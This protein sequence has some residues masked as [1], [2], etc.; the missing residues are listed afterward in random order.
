MG[1][2]SGF[3]GLNLRVHSRQATDSKA[4][5]PLASRE[6]TLFHEVGWLTHL[7]S[8]WNVAGGGEGGGEGE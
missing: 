8:K 5:I 3:K 4:D 6:G 1:F 7:P 2:N